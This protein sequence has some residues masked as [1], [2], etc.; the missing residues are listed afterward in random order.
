MGGTDW[1]NKFD[2]RSWIDSDFGLMLLS[3]EDAM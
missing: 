2:S 1:K 3:H